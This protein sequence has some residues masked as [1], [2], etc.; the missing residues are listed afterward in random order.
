MGT[1]RVTLTVTLTA[2]DDESVNR[3]Q[4]AAELALWHIDESSDFT[5]I[6]VEHEEAED[7]TDRKAHQ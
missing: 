5:A 3:A 4:D 7:I 2:D 6:A 1:Y